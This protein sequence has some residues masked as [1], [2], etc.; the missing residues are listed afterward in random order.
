MSTETNKK[1]NALEYFN[2]K[3]KELS[4]IEDT[5]EKNRAILDDI[6]QSYLKAHEDYY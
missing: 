2:S 5:E 1:L 6:H 3:L 4:S